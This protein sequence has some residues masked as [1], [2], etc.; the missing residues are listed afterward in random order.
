MLLQLAQ[1]F[2]V[3]AAINALANYDYLV[4]YL[5]KTDINGLETLNY[6]EVTR[7]PNQHLLVRVRNWSRRRN[8]LGLNILKRNLRNYQLMLILRRGRGRG[9]KI[10][11][12]NILT[13]N[14]L[15]R[16]W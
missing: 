16:W 10:L 4:G 9:R 8:Y 13:L 2:R 12:D 14:M 15:R 5:L 3:L 11:R 6:S 7:L 1:L